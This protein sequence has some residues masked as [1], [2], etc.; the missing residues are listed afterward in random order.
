M[1][2]NGHQ[3]SSL[4]TQLYLKDHDMYTKFTRYLNMDDSGESFIKF[5]EYWFQDTTPTDLSK[6]CIRYYRDYIESHL[7]VVCELIEMPIDK[8]KKLCE[9]G[10]EDI[11]KLP[12]GCSVDFFSPPTY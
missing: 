1:L 9:N 3:I 10:G 4:V 11:D 2:Y 5:L 7:Q 12:D 6:S 8:F